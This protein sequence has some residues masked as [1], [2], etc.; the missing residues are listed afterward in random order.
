MIRCNCRIVGISPFSFSAP[1][2]TPRNTGEGFDQ[3]EQ[4]IWHERIHKNAAG[5]AFI[6]PTALK[7]CLSEVAKYLSESVPGK[8]K[9]TYTKHFEAGISVIEPLMLGVQ[10]DKIDGERLFL[11]ADG[12][13]GSGKRV[14]KVYPYLPEWSANA[15][16]LVLDPI[17]KPEKVQ[18]YASFAGQFIGMGRFRPRNNGF[19]GR[20]RIE[21]FEHSDVKT[22]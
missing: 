8:G 1:V 2:R 11:P 21:D 18:E 9:A 17:I 7:N 14:W 5:E 15:E 20:F 10:A 22:F 3:W 16:I 19:Y 6:P 4:R 12:K 13:R